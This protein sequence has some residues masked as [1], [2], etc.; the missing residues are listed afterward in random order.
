[1][2]FIYF[3]HKN[4]KG[5][6]NMFSPETTSLFKWILKILTYIEFFLILTLMILCI[7]VSIVESPISA[8]NAIIEPFT[9]QLLK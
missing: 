5:D 2:I 8:M 4:T 6:F 1:M 7:Y 3:Y 9:F